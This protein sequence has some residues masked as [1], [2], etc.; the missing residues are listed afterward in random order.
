MVDVEWLTAL[1][2][3]W[4]WA[5]EFLVACLVLS[6]Y[7]AV[8]LNS[9]D[10]R[11]V[12]L[13]NCEGIIRVERALGIFVEVDVQDMILGTAAVLLV[14]YVY[15]FVHPLLTVGFIVVVFLSKRTYYSGMRNAFVVFSLI[16]F[17]VFLIYPSA[18]P[19]MMI[20]YGFV[21]LLH[22]EAPVSY[23]MELARKILNPYAAM[24]SVHFGYSLIVGLILVLKTDRIPLRLL[25]IVY[26]SLMLFS[27]TASANH[28]LLDCLASVGLLAATYLV[29]FRLGLVD[30]LTRI[31]QHRVMRADA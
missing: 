19:R 11:E 24:P 1:R 23:E 10:R 17:A 2:P 26:P 9:A 25:G 7:S 4:L 30:S 5:R 3:N 22:Q 28:L 27:V 13:E 14:S 31:F 12:A 8:N 16:S 15:A 18:P 21:D 29:V 20:E 6:A